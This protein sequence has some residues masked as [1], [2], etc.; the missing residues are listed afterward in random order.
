M[1]SSTFIPNGWALA[2]G[3][4]FGAGLGLS[5]MTLPAKVLG[6]LDVSGAWDP[7]L[8]LV[9]AAAV[10]VHFIGLRL[11]AA[12]RAP[13]FDSA[14]PP[15]ATAAIDRRLVAGAAIFGVGWG[16]SGLCPGPAVVSTLSGAVPIA[17]FVGAM[18]VGMALEN[19]VSGRDG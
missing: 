15:P 5:H 6:F 8:A 9:M 2:C 10:A 18:L 1:K 3:L 7:S 14:F 13:W 16:L 12:R 11:V 4:L 19:A 17:A